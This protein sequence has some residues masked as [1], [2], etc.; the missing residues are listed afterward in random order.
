MTHSIFSSTFAI[1]LLMVSA[2][3]LFPCPIDKV[4]GND[5]VI[6]LRKKKEVEAKEEVV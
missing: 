2:N 5:A 4:H 6:D 3:S 1:C